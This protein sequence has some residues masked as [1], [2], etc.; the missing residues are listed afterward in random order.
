[1]RPLSDQF[2]TIP[3]E[4]GPHVLER[5]GD[6]SLISDVRSCVRPTELVERKLQIALQ[7]NR[8]SVHLVESTSTHLSLVSEQ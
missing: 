7:C 5:L 1:M 3:R 8:D 6:E 2:P 4:Q